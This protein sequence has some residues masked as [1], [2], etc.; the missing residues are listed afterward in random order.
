MVSNSKYLS[1]FVKLTINPTLNEICGR[2][3]RGENTCSPHGLISAIQASLMFSFFVCLFVVIYQEKKLHVDWTWWKSFSKLT[4]HDDR[5]DEKFPWSR[6]VGLLNVPFCLST[7]TK[8]ENCTKVSKN[9]NPNLL[10]QPQSIQQYC[11][12]AGNI[13]VWDFLPPCLLFKT[14]RTQWFDNDLIA[15]YFRFEYSEATEL[16]RFFGK[17][18]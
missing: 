11:N 10:E 2:E 6:P 14:L 15:R 1:S 17:I 9:I 13:L 7:M 5:D 18:H 3:W 8:N 12:A 4:R 16:C